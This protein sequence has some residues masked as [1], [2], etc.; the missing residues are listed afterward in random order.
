MKK[1]LMLAAA[2]LMF[3]S[4]PA[5]ADTHEGDKKKMERE[6]KGDTNGDGVISKSEFLDRAEERFSGMDANG[7]GSIDREEAKAAH[8]KKRE[9]MKERKEQL[10]EKRAERKA[11]KEAAE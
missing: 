5:F 6:I 1:L 11:A 10:K 7:D 8:A 9:E 2:I 4:L 3:Q